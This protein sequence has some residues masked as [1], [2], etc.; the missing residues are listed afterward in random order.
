[1]AAPGILFRT[2]RTR[3]RSDP[4]GDRA[5]GCAAR[6]QDHPPSAAHCGTR[7]PWSSSL[8][9]G[10]RAHVLRVGA[11][12]SPASVRTGA[13]SRCRTFRRSTES[14]TFRSRTS[15]SP[16]WRTTPQSGGPFSQLGDHQGD[17]RSLPG[18]LGMG[19]LD[20]S[21]AASRRR[22]EAPSAREKF[23][24]FLSNPSMR[25]ACSGS[26]QRTAMQWVRSP[27]RRL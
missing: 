4:T 23:K 8:R 16:R 7:S 6:G 19:V 1:M 12:G 5:L 20:R 22:C 25:T 27:R 18:I 11:G 21:H 3:P 24:V 15:S 2:G 14:R 17:D 26:C 9:I 10:R 13:F